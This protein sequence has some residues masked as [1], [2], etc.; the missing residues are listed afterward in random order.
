LQQVRR[1]RQKKPQKN[2]NKSKTNN[3]KSDNSQKSSQSDQT[4]RPMGDWRLDS[5][6]VKVYV[7][8]EMTAAPQ[9]PTTM[10]NSS[11][12]NNPEPSTKWER[13][14]AVKKPV[15]PHTVQQQSVK[16]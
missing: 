15:E 9:R 5:K 1:S 13:V 14:D 10:P 2:K 12:L 16:P 8:P 3:I 7:G 6:G 11:R 4:P